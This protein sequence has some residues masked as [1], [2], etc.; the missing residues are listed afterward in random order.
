MA[1]APVADAAVTSSHSIANALEQEEKR[2]AVAAWKVR[3]LYIQ[4][5]DDSRHVD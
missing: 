4:A 1:A 5:Y 2:R 3:A